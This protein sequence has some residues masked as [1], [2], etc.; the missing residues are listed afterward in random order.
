MMR[1]YL[2]IL[3]INLIPLLSQAQANDEEDSR[4]LGFVINTGFNGELYALQVAP[5]VFY[6]NEKSQF[7]FGIG[8]NPINRVEETFLS[9]EIN[10]KY[11]PNG[12]NRKYNLYFITRLSFVHNER[13]TYYPAT[14]NYLFLYGG[15]GF[16]IKLFEG[17]YLGT[18]IS[19]GAFSFN[20][21]SQNPY[22]GFSKSA[23]FDEIGMGLET[24]L[25]IGYRF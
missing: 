23:F 11:F 13:N 22:E 4:K 5:S 18:N 12:T 7:E 15:Y 21:N 10:H 14:Y 2:I 9:G 19:M 24:Q 17:A 20:K 3:F 25:H 6:G 8:F 1:N 16:Q